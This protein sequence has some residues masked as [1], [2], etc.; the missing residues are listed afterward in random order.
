MVVA[1][2]LYCAAFALWRRRR[3]QRERVIRQCCAVAAG[4]VCA[5]RRVL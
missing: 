4:G 3:R 1:S 5:C 2:L